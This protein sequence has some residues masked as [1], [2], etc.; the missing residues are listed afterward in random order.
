MCGYA[1]KRQSQK[2]PDH[3]LSDF[4]TIAVLRF[5]IRNKPVNR[6]MH[7]LLSVKAEDGRLDLPSKEEESPAGLVDLPHKIGSKVCDCYPAPGIGLAYEHKGSRQNRAMFDQNGSRFDYVHD[8]PAQSEAR[9]VQLAGLSPASYDYLRPISSADRLL[10]GA[11]VGLRGVSPSIVQQR[12]K[13][14]VR[15]GLRLL[16]A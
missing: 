6:G 15:K 9:L 4:Q 1:R 2:G 11:P 13:L 10:F 3:D 7:C 16:A 12:A 5:R 14:R 8:S